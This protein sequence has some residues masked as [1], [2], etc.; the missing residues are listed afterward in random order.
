[1]LTL[2]LGIA[3]I[4]GGLLRIFLATQ[5]KQGTPWVWVVLSGVITL[6]LGVMIGRQVAG[7]EL[8]RPGPIPRHRPNLCRQ[9]AGFRSAWRSGGHAR[10]LRRRLFS[11]YSSL[12]VCV[13]ACRLTDQDRALIDATARNDIEAAPPADCR[14]RQL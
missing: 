8:L 13:P 5:M 14:R 9:Q 11:C 3:L 4:V 6:L 2:M 10:L 1:M 7:L 12:L